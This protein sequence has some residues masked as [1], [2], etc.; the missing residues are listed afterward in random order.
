MFPLKLF[1]HFIIEYSFPLS[2]AQILD[3]VHLQRMRKKEYVHTDHPDKLKILANVTL[4]K[5]VTECLGQ[6]AQVVG[7]SFSTPKGCRFD[8][9][10]GRVWEAAD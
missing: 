10:S 1:Y 4:T 3:Y 7:A 5:K 2:N 8:P 9:W 6:V